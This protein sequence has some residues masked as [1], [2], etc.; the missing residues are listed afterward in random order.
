MTINDVCYVVV[1]PLYEL[2]TVFS[3]LEA[4]EDLVDNLEAQDFG[5]YRVV[6][7]PFVYYKGEFK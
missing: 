3:T 2:D 7:V 6:K 5:K 1:G 4:A